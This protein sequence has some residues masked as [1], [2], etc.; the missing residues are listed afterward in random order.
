MTNISEDQ[1]QEP[2]HWK[3]NDTASILRSVLRAKGIATKKDVNS[4]AEKTD[5]QMMEQNKKID[6][7]QQA[8]DEKI[9]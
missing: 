7:C 6:K 3:D 8:N 4:I 9:K 5:K 2:W 1:W